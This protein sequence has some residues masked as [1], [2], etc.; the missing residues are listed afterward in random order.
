M[1]LGKVIGNVVA[2]VKHP[3]YKD[4][5]LMLVAPMQPDGSLKKATMLAVDTVDA[6]INDVVL[7]ISEGKSASEILEFEKRVPIRSVIIAVVDHVDISEQD[8]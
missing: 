8:Q 2:T 7:V 3:S 6:G 4:Q 5:K 1:Y